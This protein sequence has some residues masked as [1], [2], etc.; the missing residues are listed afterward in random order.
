MCRSEQRAEE[1]TAEELYNQIQAEKQKL[2]KAGKIKKE[3]PL[4]AITNDEKP[5]EI[6]QSWK[7]VRLGEIISISSGDGLTAKDMDNLG[8]YPVYGGNG[9]TGYHN[10]YNVTKNTLVIG[11]VGF[12]CGSTHITESK[13]WITDN[14]FITKFDEAKIDIKW[15]KNFIDYLNPRKKASSTAQPVISGKLLY[16]MLMPLI[17]LAEQKRIPML[18]ATK[19]PTTNCSSLI[20][21]SPVTCKNLYCSLP[22]RAG[23]F[24]NARRKAMPKTFINKYKPKSKISSKQAK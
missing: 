15:L 19:K 17:P 23:L 21:A 24:P 22:F 11:R 14:A 10:L 3:K 1:G 6:P 20:N 2:I 18:N 8:K 9:I 5:F 4:P 7:W 13:A 16:P 12:Y